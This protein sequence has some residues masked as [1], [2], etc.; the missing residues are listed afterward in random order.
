[1]AFPPQGGCVQ[2]IRGSCEPKTWMPGTSPGMTWICWRR[3]TLI[4]MAGLVPAI[5]DFLYSRR[6]RQVRQLQPEMAFDEFLHA[7]EVVGQHLLVGALLDA[8]F[9]VDLVV[10]RARPAE[11]GRQIGEIAVDGV[12]HLGAA[13]LGPEQ[14]V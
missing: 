10:L 4:V 3:S 12:L 13:L 6:G 5:H 1:M 14:L 11:E 7:G 8:P 2:H 9:A